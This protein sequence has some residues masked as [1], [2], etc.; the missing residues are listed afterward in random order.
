MSGELDC[1]ELGTADLLAGWVG[2]LQ[3]R[4]CHVEPRS[5]RGAANEP[6]QH[7]QRAQHVS[8]PRGR[9][10][11]EQAMLNRVP[12]GRPR[13]IVAHR[14]LQ[15]ALVREVLKAFFESSRAHAVASAGIG[16]DHQT[17]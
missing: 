13:R 6:Q 2:L 14:D 9:H 8:R 4:G 1:V 16:F 15:P 3:M 5:R 7:G 10:L 11:A 17:S 12:L